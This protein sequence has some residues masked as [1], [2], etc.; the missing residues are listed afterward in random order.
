LTR[1]VWTTEPSR[2]QRIAIESS[3]ATFMNF[4]LTTEHGDMNANSLGPFLTVPS[5]AGSFAIA[6]RLTRTRG[7][8]AHPHGPMHGYEFGD[9]N[10]HGAQGSHRQGATAAGRRTSLR[11]PTSVQ[12]TI[13]PDVCPTPPAAPKSFPDRC[14]FRVRAK[15]TFSFREKH[16]PDAAC[17]KYE[18]PHPPASPKAEKGLRPRLRA[19]ALS[20]NVSPSFLQHLAKEVPNTEKSMGDRGD[21]IDTLTSLDEIMMLPNRVGRA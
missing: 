3:A 8:S 11:R 9:L 1:V 16:E 4:E 21:S 13:V 5:V 20:S 10:Q 14:K 6:T 7:A 19:S 18:V 2:L 15:S 12:T 17:G